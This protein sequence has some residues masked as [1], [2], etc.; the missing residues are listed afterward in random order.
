[1]RLAPGA[2]AGLGREPGGRKGSSAGSG[3]RMQA[4]LEPFVEPELCFARVIAR[5]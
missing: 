1:M 3:P 5:D 2:A 4:E